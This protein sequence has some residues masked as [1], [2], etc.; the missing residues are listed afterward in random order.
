M[1][2]LVPLADT[3]EDFDVAETAAPEHPGAEPLRWSAAQV[4][5]QTGLEA[6]LDGRGVFVLCDVPTPAQV[7]ILVGPA[8]S[9]VARKTVNLLEGETLEMVTMVLPVGGAS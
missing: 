5:R 8:G 4:G 7:R 3:W 1:V 2:R 6:I 9:E